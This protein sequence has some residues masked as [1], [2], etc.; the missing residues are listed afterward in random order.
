M[1]DSLSQISG[2]SSGIDFKSLVDQIITLDRRPAVK[3]QATLDANAKRREAY[4]QY[5]TALNALKTASD[6]L[7]TG[8]AFDA[9]STTSNGTDASGRNVL[10]AAALAGSVPGQYKVEVTSLAAAQKTIGTVGQTSTST[11]L[12]LTGTLVI[13]GQ[14]VVIDATDTLNGIRDKIN[15][16]TGTTNVQAS[17]V[18]AN[19]TDNRL[20][21]GGMK[22][23]LANAFTITDDPSNAVSLVAALG[24][25]GAP[26]TA[27]ADAVVEIDDQIIVT[28]PTNTVADAIGGVTLTLAALGTS[29]VTVERL[30]SAGTK[31]AQAF[32]D[33]YNK[34]VNLGKQLTDGSNAVLARDSLIRGTRV[35]MATEVLASVA[36]QPPAVQTLSSIGISLAKDGTMTLD[37]TKLQDAYAAQP[38]DVR[39]L[40]ADRIGALETIMTQTTQIGGAID[41]R[42]ASLTTRNDQLQIRIDDLGS[43]L[44][45]KRSALLMQYARFEATLGK[46]K[47]IGD[48]MASQFAGLAK[49]ND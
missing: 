6:S 27:A 37:A 12:G 10:S 31:A 30:P 29:T 32:V 14:N 25:G 28:R 8:S 47:S 9:F 40:L 3:W 11:A 49:D 7:K 35:N 22:T 24:L 36:T 46:L 38:T 44:D 39:A 23:G 18:S 34:V 19:A 41:A 16:V 17:V 42:E 5:R 2:L 21:L 4:E 13:G 48:S 33:A 20:V 45:K 15:L 26:Q 1:A 43:R